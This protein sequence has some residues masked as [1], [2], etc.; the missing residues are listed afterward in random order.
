M[1]EVASGRRV[2]S[3]EN[4]L[5]FMTGVREGPTLGFD[6]QPS[7]ELLVAVVSEAAVVTGANH[8]HTEGENSEHNCTEEEANMKLFD[9]LRV[10]LLRS[11]QQVPR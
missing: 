3:L 1:R 8:D 10:R 5:D 2:T 4:V 9:Y 7:I 11:Y 6:L